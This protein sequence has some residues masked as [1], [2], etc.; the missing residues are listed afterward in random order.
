MSI[1]YEKESYAKKGGLVNL[2]RDFGKY[3]LLNKRESIR[4]E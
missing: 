2:P 4:R 3:L 1:T